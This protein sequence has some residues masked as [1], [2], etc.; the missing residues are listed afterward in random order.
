MSALK[1]IAAADE[2]DAYRTGLSWE[3][4][5]ELRREASERHAWWVAGAAC[6]IAICAVAG[7]AML[8]PLRRVVPYLYMMDKATGNLEYVGAVDDR[9][10]KGYQELL[11]K[12]WAQVYINARESY[13]YPLL[14][15]DYDTVMALSDESV[16]RDYA[17]RYEGPNA[18]DKQYGAR[19]ELA[20]SIIS[21][22]LAPSSVGTQL[23]ARFSRTRRHVDT[24][25]RE[26]VEYF[27]AT[28]RYRYLPSMLDAEKQL[29]LNPLGYR[30][31]GYRIDAELAPTEAIAAPATTG[32]T[33]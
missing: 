28:I 15:S 2:P 23:V 3:A 4:S 21:L 26:P 19:I 17:R 10:V 32:R 7:I 14:Q 27:V 25:Y 6:L 8:A 33:P 16:G 30:V 24:D 31:A 18:L 12:H 13:H 22:R 20:T 9:A 5:L 1:N 29:L 11:D